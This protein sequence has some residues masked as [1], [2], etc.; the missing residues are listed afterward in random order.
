MNSIMNDQLIELLLSSDDLERFKYLSK[1]IKN[2]NE[3]PSQIITYQ[4][5]NNVNK[6]MTLLSFAVK[7]G[8]YNCTT[9]LLILD[10][11]E[12]CINYQDKDGYTALHYA[13]YYGYIKIVQLLISYCNINIHLFNIHNETAY[14]AAKIKKQKEVMLYLE[15]IINYNIEDIN[16]PIKK[17]DNM[18]NSTTNNLSKDSINNNNKMSIYDASLMK[19]RIIDIHGTGDDSFINKE[20]YC[21]ST[22]QT[23][24][25]MIYH[26]K[27]TNHMIDNNLSIHGSTIISLLPCEDLYIGINNLYIYFFYL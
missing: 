14:D 27:K 24:Q 3:L 20:F 13:C 17:N 8:R 10:A 5:R 2:L 6:L 9:Y 11:S 21:L 25:N 16:N 15:Q 23:Q 4:N 1:D 26:E 19:I 7:Q 22:I 18:N 12:N